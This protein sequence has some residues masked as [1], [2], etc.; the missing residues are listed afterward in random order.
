MHPS[1][2]FREIGS[3]V[4]SEIKHGFRDLWGVVHDRNKYSNNIFVAPKMGKMGKKIFFFKLG[5][6]PCTAEQPQG[7]MELQEK[8]AQKD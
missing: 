5:F 8:E 6:M 1:G 2:S 3:L 4:F 7:S